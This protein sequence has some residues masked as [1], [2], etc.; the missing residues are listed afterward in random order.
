MS[1]LTGYYTLNTSLIALIQQPY[2]S[3]TAALIISFCSV[4][5]S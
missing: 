5:C 2:H 3:Y 4:F 1:V